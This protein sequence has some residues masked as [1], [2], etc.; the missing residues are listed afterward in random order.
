MYCPVLFLR[1]VAG[2]FA[3]DG[4]EVQK[5][6]RMK[7]TFVLLIVPSYCALCQSK[8]IKALGTRFGSE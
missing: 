7:K 6:I 8:C 2:C 3:V 1:S 5:F 4:D